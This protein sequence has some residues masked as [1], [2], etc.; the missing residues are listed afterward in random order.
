[1][2]NFFGTIEAMGLLRDILETSLNVMKNS[3]MG[4]T[5]V[6]GSWESFNARFLINNAFNLR[7]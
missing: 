1:M 2:E 6:S 5:Y 4:L 3:A 7:L